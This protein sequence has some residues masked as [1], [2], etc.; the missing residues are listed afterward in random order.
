[1][2]IRPYGKLGSQLR[3]PGTGRAGPIHPTAAYCPPLIKCQV[4]GSG[5]RR[6]SIRFPPRLPTQSGYAGTMLFA[7]PVRRRSTGPSTPAG[8]IRTTPALTKGRPGWAALSSKA[9]FLLD[10]PRPVLFLTLAKREWGGGFLRQS[11]TSRKP[12]G[13]SAA[14]QPG[15][16]VISRP[17]STWKCRWNTLC[18][19]C[20]PMLETTR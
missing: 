2:E 10:R 14:A 13:Q 4:S 20:S 12:S 7:E 9:F 16:Q 6:W 15:G 18:P 17:L 3:I 19:A 8:P 1:M 11:R 5:K